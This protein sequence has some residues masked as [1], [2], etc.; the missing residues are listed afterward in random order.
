DFSPI[1]V[2]GAMVLIYLVLGMF[3]E[4]IAMMLMTLPVTYPIAMAL[5]LDPIWFGVFLVLMIEVGLITPPVGMVL[6]VLRSM[7]D[8]ARFGDII[9]GALP[10][11]LMILLFLCLI[12]AFPQ[13]VM[14]LPQQVK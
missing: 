3:V 14:W 12:Y 8:K 1:L 2:M 7:N 4:S 10:F 9:R 5:G 13:I 6:F 11:V